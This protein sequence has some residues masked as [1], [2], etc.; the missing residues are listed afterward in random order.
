MTK[1]TTLPGIEPLGSAIFDETRK[2]RYV[3]WRHFGEGPTL[4]FLM[5]NPS[6]A[7]ESVNDPTVRRCI[8]FAQ[9]WG[10]GHLA[11]LNIFA[12]RST[13]P[14]LLYKEED[15]IG[16]DNDKWIAEIAGKSDRLIAAWGTHG[17][18]NNRGNDVLRL[19][20]QIGCACYALQLTNG[21]MPKHPLY[22]RKDLEP[23]RY[24]I[25]D[26]G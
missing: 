11:V 21:G 1:Q 5:L 23:V 17:A 15:P 24:Y 4:V 20:Q 12:L 13:D 8:G 18:L 6:T 22:L 25:S 19:L 16:P 9:D 14:R 10:Y 2:Y 26:I 3:L 7:D